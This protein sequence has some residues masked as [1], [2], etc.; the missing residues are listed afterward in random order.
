LP[1]NTKHHDVI[2]TERY[3]LPGGQR[4]KKLTKRFDGNEDFIR[5]ERMGKVERHKMF[6]PKKEKLK[7]GHTFGGPRKRREML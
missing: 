2:S 7:G 6:Q 3:G 1:D 5:F 4:L